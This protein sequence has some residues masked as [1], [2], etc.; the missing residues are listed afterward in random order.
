MQVHHTVGEF[1]QACN[2]LRTGGKTL[3]FVP[4]MGALHEGHSS[5]MRRARMDGCLPIV[6]IF[7]NPTQ[8]GP[9]EDFARYPRTLDADLALCDAE[10]VGAV[11]APS[12]EEM[13]PGGNTT[14]VSVSGVSEGLCGASRPNHFDGVATVVSK[15]L[16]ACGPCSAYFGRKDYQQY[17]VVSRMASDLLLPVSIVGCTTVRESD[18]LA[19]SSRNRYLSVAE[20]AAALA[21]PRGLAAAHRMFDEGERRP[22]ALIEVVTT[23]LRRA[24]LRE[25]YVALREPLDLTPSEQLQR[26]P[27]RVLLA[28][29][30]YSGN[31]RLIDNLVLGEDAAP[32]VEGV[33]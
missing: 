12:V 23:Q 11:F 27:E 1:R 3:G 20:R 8:F 7:V 9:N 19:L 14:R 33:T 29:A 13:Y 30:A 21:I 26:L 16:I 22:Q 5:L 2:A 18:G 17:R 28:V 24:Q 25:D 15:L 10:G 4:T 6:S 31:T 32:Q